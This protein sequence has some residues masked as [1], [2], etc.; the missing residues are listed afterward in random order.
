[1]LDAADVEVLDSA[2][3]LRLLTT[4]SIGRVIF[5][6]RALPDVVL[7]NFVLHGGMIV[8]PTGKGSKL[9]TAV[10]NVVVAFEVDDFDVQTWTGWSVTVLGRAR[11]VC[12]GD[13]LTTLSTLDLRSPDRGY[14][15]QFVVISADIINGRRRAAGDG[16]A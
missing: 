8:V 9:S 5:T 3:C 10:R 11:L 6:A 16:V 15:E 12:G 2:E 14:Q 4:V 13:E 7:V 1:M